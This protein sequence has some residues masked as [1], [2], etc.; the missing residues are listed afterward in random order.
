MG[1]TTTFFGQF[2]LDRK[3]DPETHIFLNKLATTRRIARIGLDPK[4][5]VEGEFFVEET[6]SAD[7]STPPKTQPGLW[8]QWIPTEDGLHIEWDGV[9]KFYKYFEWLQ[10][11][12][13]RI[14]TPK[15]YG[16]EGIVTFQGSRSGGC[17]VTLNRTVFFCPVEALDFMGDKPIEFL[18]IKKNLPCLMGMHEEFDKWIGKELKS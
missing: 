13:D 16:L 9:E 6:L 15:S 17:I 1:S 12:I 11:I 8:C 18:K 5:G 4:Y 2:D 14:L 10:Y 3:L 7:S